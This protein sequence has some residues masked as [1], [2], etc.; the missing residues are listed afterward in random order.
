MHKFLISC[1][2]ASNH[3]PDELITILGPQKKLLQSHRAYDQGAL[4]AAQ[5][6]AEATGAKLISGTC[7][8]LAVDLNRGQKN[9]RRFSV[10]TRTLNSDM[11][12]K[13]EKVWYQ[14]Y[15]DSVKENISQ[16]INKNFQAVHLSIHS[17]TP[18]L[19]GIKRETDIGLLYDPSRK[20]ERVFAAKFKESFAI[21]NPHLRVRCNYPYKGVSDGIA[22]WLRKQF[23]DT[24]YIGFEIELNQKLLKNSENWNNCLQ[25]CV[26]AIKSSIRQ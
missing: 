8:R 26:K 16:I 1:E 2:H 12:G 21:T 10:Y 5:V 13:L 11:L 25:N 14:P 20:P 23:E 24:N 9:P 3:V 4:E 15:R 17:F 19:N 22:S 18:V 6:I 7:T